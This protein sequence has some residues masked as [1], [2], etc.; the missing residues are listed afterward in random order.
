MVLRR[1]A[2]VLA[3]HYQFHLRDEGTVY[4][5]PEKWPDEALADRYLLATGCVAIAT[6]KNYFV[7]VTIEISEHEPN[8]V[9]SDWDHI[10]ECSVEFA[11]GRV[12]LAGGPQTGRDAQMI[13]LNTA[14]WWRLLALSGNLDRNDPDTTDDYYKI[15]FWRRPAAEPLLRKRYRAA[16]EP[17]S[18]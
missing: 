18:V 12:V 11:T 10:V 16:A 1:E 5:F 8:I 9:Q 17:E 7:P 14:G 13:T 2:T 4:V 15:V 6:A 3:D